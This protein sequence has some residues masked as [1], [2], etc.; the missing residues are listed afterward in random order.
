MLPLRLVLDTN[1]IVSAAIKP[2]GLQRT[3]LLLAMTRPA[4]LYLTE[5]IF[6][7]YQLV[8]RRPEFKIQKSLRLQLLQRIE[9][10]SFLVRP[11]RRIQATADPDDNMFL[12]CADAARADY[13]VTGNLRLFPKFWKQTKIVSSR[14][15]IAMITPHLIP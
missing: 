14:E 2:D 10:I 13:L 9:D 7:E 11:S 5:P 12:E 3:V 8:L 1:I 15:F 6:S 4:R